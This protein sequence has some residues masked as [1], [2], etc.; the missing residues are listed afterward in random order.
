MDGWKDGSNDKLVDERINGWAG[1]RV[2][3]Q[4]GRWMGDEQIEAAVDGW[5]DRWVSDRQ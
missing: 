2:S 3:E 1:Q 5:M 4:V